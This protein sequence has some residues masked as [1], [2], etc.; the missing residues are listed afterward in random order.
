VIDAPHHDPCASLP[1]AETPC[2]GVIIGP[3]LV[4]PD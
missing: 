3:I 1:S 4:S 2:K